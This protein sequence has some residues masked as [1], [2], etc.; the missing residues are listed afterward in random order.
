MKKKVINTA[1]CDAREVTEESLAGF[2]SITI[3]AGVLIIGERS[4]ELLNRYPVTMN[5]ANVLELPDGQNIAV[6]IV[7][8]KSELG[9]EADG[10]GAFLLVNGKLT[11]ADGSQ[12]AVKSYCRIVVNGKVLMPKSYEGHFPNIQVNG[13][14]EYY[15]DGSTILKADTEIDDLFIARAANP[16]Y[17]C[18]G[19]LFFLDTAID[20][21]KLYA[22]GI[23]FAAQRIIIAESLVDKLILMFDEEAKIVRVPEG[24][25][26]IDDDVEL[27]PKTIRKYGTKLCVIGDVSIRDAEALSSLEYLFADGTVSVNK[28]LEDA[29]DEIESVVDEL[30]I[31]DPDLGYITDRPM[32]RI[33]SV[34]LGKYPIGVRVEDCAKVTLSE[35]LTSEDIMEK[36]Y[37]EDC[38][39]VVCTK[40]QEEAVNMIAEDVA[41]IRISGQDEE[42]EDQDGSI[43]GRLKGVLGKLKDTQVINSAEYKM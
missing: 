1:V 27:K 4:K 38:A 39:V 20:M 32:V 31:I 18:P 23:R 28:E 30:K 7:N 22:K 35:D 13:K 17:Y 2:E 10:T 6:K 29:F 5:V 42:D 24:T 34:M 19:N 12:D 26:L 15:P 25:K 16:L 11:I 37:I 40:E 41:M 33:G 21:E 43:G 36:L 8:G 9:P 3:N 14:T